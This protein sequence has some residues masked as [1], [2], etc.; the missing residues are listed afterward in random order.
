[1]SQSPHTIRNIR[2]GVPLGQPPQIED[3]LWVGLIDSYCKLPMALTAE[4]LGEQTGITKDEVDQY[5][6]RSQQ[7]WKAGKYIKAFICFVQF[8]KACAVHLKI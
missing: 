5:A 7:L 2:F 4:K 1:M 3:S 6:L 8:L